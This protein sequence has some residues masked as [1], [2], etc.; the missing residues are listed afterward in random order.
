MPAD[1]I[2]EIG[3]LKKTAVL[4]NR[5]L[6]KLPKEKADLIIAAADEVVAGKLHAQF[7]PQIWQ[8]GNGS[9]TNMNVR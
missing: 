2:R 9:Q 4:V 6:R 8:T 1:L 3:V 7:P 5:D